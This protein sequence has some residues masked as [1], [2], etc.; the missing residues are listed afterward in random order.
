MLGVTTQL[1]IERSA[2]HTPAE[3]IEGK[4]LRKP[5]KPLAYAKSLRLAWQ[6]TTLQCRF[7]GNSRNQLFHIIGELIF[8]AVPEKRAA[9]SL[10][11]EGQWSR[12]RG[13]RVDEVIVVAEAAVA[14]SL[15]GIA[16][17]RWVVSTMVVVR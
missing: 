11:G 6:K 14:R 15:V 7:S 4:E 3:G 2:C 16:M 9:Y 17:V 12:R 1:I 10:D 5:S 8:V 13:S